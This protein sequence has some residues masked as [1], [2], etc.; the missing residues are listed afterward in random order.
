MK[1]TKDFVI[2]LIGLIIVS[3]FYVIASFGYKYL[4]ERHYSFKYIF[5]ISLLSGLMVYVIKVPLFY[6]YGL[7]NALITYMLYMIVVS[8]A[9]TLYSTL[10]LR[11]K[12][13]IHTYIILSII[14][15][16]FLLDEYLTSLYKK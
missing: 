7:D 16:L 14:I 15:S 9:V 1:I 13:E 2:L 6:Y 8:V 10:V 5:L 4:E 11:E 3:I 12:I